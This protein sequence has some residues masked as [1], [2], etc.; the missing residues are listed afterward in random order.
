MTVSDSIGSGTS[1]GARALADSVKNQQMN[2]QMLIE[3]DL[4][5]KGDANGSLTGVGKRPAD[6]QDGQL[7]GTVV[8]QQGD[9]WVDRDSAEAVVSR[10]S[11]PAHIAR[12]PQYDPEKHIIYLYHVQQAA[13]ETVCM[14]VRVFS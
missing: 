14:C 2:Q 11:V 3:N 1:S 13:G 6:A 7:D 5:S 9:F 8:M 12:I 10:A 4:M